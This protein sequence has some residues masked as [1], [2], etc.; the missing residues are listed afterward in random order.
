MTLDSP[1]HIKLVKNLRKIGFYPN[2]C[3]YIFKNFD[4]RRVKDALHYYWWLCKF[5]EDRKYE[6]SYIY[7]L[8]HNFDVTKTYKNYQDYLKDKKDASKLVLP[9][10]KSYTTSEHKIGEDIEREDSPKNILDF[11]RYAKESK[12]S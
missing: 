1:M 3:K 9:E 10:R 7:S 8:F 2:E 4:E 11:I 6:K 5:K 12:D